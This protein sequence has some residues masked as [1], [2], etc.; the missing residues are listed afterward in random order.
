M[1]SEKHDSTLLNIESKINY[2]TENHWDKDLIKRLN[3][4]Y[5]FLLKKIE[6]FNK[7]VN[8]YRKEVSDK[9]CKDFRKT[10]EITEEEWEAYIN[11]ED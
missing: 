9:I 8:F 10:L 5:D 4:Y 11:N 3:C 6:N 2:I 1:Y 7:I